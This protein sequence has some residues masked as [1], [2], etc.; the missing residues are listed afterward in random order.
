[1]VCMYQKTPLVNT[2]ELSPITSSQQ[3][4]IMKSPQKTVLFQLSCLFPTWQ[5]WH[6]LGYCLLNLTQWYEQWWNFS[7]SFHV[8]HS[9]GCPVSRSWWTQQKEGKIHGWNYATFLTKS[10]PQRAFQNRLTKTTA[11][12]HDK[13]HVVEMKIFTHR[14]SHIQQCDYHALSTRRFKIVT[15]CLEMIRE[16]GRVGL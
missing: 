10:W 8:R 3:A 12:H 9:P 14:L 11:T 7:F 6:F 16:S 15:V 2:S 13:V 4:E 1:M 5:S